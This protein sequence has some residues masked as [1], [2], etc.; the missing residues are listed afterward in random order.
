MNLVI[1]LK[2]LI[3]LID[4]L[5]KKLKNQLPII[6]NFDKKTDNVNLNIKNTTSK[7][8]VY[9][10]KNSNCCLFSFI[11]VEILVILILVLG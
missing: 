4:K 7:L 3:I 8:D 9:L 10:Q 1:L 2:K 5:K 11:A 6:N